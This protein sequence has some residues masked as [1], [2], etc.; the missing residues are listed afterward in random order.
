MNNSFNYSTFSDLM[1]HELNTEK[2]IRHSESL[3]RD[4]RVSVEDMTEEQT[5]LITESELD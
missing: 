5:S 3:H 4:S 2:D 1:I